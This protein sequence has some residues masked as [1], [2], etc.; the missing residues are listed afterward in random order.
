MEWLKGNWVAL[1]AVLWGIEHFLRLLDDLLP[2][3]IKLDNNIADILAN[4]LKAF[5]PKRVQ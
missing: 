4:I 5:F 1:V 3:K 2:E